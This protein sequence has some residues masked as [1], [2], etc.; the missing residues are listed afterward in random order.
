MRCESIAALALSVLP[1][2]SGKYYLLTGLNK[3]SLPWERTQY[4]VL[5]FRSSIDL[6]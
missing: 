4:Q 3:E 1:L 6:G 5:T 2:V